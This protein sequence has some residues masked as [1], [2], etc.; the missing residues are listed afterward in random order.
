[1]AERR[2]LRRSPD[3]A[4]FD[5]DQHR[6]VTLAELAADV[7]EGRRFR[8]RHADTDEVCT[9]RVLLE[10]LQASAIPHVPA[11]A[12]AQAMTGSLMSAFVAGT[13]DWQRRRE[14]GS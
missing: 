11:T 13:R 12:G 2:E 7:R 9:Q 10:V 14:E 1:V 3:G 5:V 8:A 6:Q 4:L